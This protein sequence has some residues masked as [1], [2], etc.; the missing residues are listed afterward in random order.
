MVDGRW[1]RSFGPRNQ[2]LVHHGFGWMDM[3]CRFWIILVEYV[4]NHRVESSTD[5]NGYSVLIPWLIN[6][7]Q[8]ANQQSTYHDQPATRSKCQL[9]SYG[10]PQ[11]QLL[12]AS[13]GQASIGKSPCCS[14]K[15]PSTRR[16]AMPWAMDLWICTTIWWSLGDPN[17]GDQ[18]GRCMCLF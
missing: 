2:P 12:I 18:S 15:V 10:Q 1:F 8:P 3:F 14:S 4:F 5:G 17:D 6:H 11:N 13:A 7:D 9:L 16:V